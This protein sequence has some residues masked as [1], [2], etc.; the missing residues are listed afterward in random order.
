MGGY[1]DEK[2]HNSGLKNLESKGGK[3][4]FTGKQRREKQ[5]EKE[6]KK[7]E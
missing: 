1:R 4:A 7:E 2:R 6:N 5:Q 3:K